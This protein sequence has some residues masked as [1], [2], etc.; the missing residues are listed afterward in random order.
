MA[1]YEEKILPGLLDLACSTRDVMAL[2]AKIVPL[3]RGR[4]L[5]VG[6]GSGHNLALYYSGQV[7]LVWGLEPSAGMRGRAQRNLARSAVEVRW[8]DLPGE[9]IPL[10]DNSVDTVLLTFTLCTIPDWRLALQQMARVLKP[11]G[12]LLFCEHGRAPDVAVSRW[13]DRLNPLWKRLFG[14]C[15]LNRPIADYL[16]EGGFAIE[17]LDSNYAEGMPRFAGYISMGQAVKG[18]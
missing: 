18:Q 1:F 6:I 14:G 12:K 13:Q 3:A 16:A 11:G 4:V 5:E 9:Q 10:E 7:E 17:Q 2:R 15:H 8:L